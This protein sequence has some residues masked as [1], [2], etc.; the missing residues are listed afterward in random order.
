MNVSFITIHLIGVETFH[1]KPQVNLMVVLEESETH[2]V[3]G[4][5][6]LETM[7]VCKKVFANPFSRC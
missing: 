7:N 3:N 5:R 4:I 2:Q 1:S 6:H